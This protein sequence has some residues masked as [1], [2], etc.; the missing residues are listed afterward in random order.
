[1]LCVAGHLSAGIDLR[2]EP[3]SASIHIPRRIRAEAE[4]GN[5]PERINGT[6]PEHSARLCLSRSHVASKNL[7]VVS[8]HAVSALDGE[9]RLAY[10][11]KN[12]RKIMVLLA[13]I[14]LAT[15]PL[16]RECSTTELQQQLERFVASQPESCKPRKRFF[17]KRISRR[18]EFFPYAHDAPALRST[19]LQW[20]G[21]QGDGGQ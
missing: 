11:G 1:M 16:P 12:V 20:G 9:I 6:G 21:P 10:G 7:S 4:N 14:E 2:L 8:Y 5:G 13:R 3:L 19:S 17:V 15:S 18:D